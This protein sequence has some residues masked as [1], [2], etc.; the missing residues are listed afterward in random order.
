[1]NAQRHK[2]HPSIIAVSDSHAIYQEAGVGI[3]AIGTC[4]G[5][6]NGENTRHLEKNIIVLE[7]KN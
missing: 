7:K 1:M 3:R 4:H 5:P 6:E 2:A